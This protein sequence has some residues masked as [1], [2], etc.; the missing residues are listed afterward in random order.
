MP[1]Y[2]AMLGMQEFLVIGALVALI[3]G[4]RK[5]PELGKGLGLGM[6]EFKK[7]IMGQEVEDDPAKLAAPEET[8]NGESE[9]KNTDKAAS[10]ADNDKNS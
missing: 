9:T 1:I 8:E 4:A 10:Q 5:L 6:R 7:G 2:Q 3:F